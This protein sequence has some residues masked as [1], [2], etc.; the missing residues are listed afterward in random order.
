MSEAKVVVVT[1]AAQGIGRAIAR[2]FA[3]KGHT[4]ILADINEDCLGIT[5]E[6]LKGEGPGWQLDK[7]VV[8][9]RSETSVAALFDYIS[10]THGRLHYAVNNAGIVGAFT[11]LLSYPIEVFDNVLAVNTRGVF[12]CMKHEIAMMVNNDP[13]GGAI[14]NLASVAGHTAEPCL[15]A[16]TASKHAIIGLSAA[17]AK[18]VGKQGIR[19]NCLCPGST[20][21]PMLRGVMEVVQELTKNP[22][23]IKSLNIP[24]ERLGDPEEMAKAAVFL[25]T[26]ATYMTGQ[27]LIMDGGRIC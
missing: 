13:P 24:M 21:T 10:D 4:V 9:V 20:E 26:E 1:G 17:C 7:Y 16:Y 14:V 22:P 27:S 11:P 8:D 6:E 3:T 2:E 12:L 19:V 18:E 23:D 25:C 15:S 5:F